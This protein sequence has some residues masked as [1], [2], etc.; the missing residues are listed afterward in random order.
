MNKLQINSKIIWTKESLHKKHI[1]DSIYIKF[2]LILG[3]RI[4][5]SGYLQRWVVIDCEGIEEIFWSCENI[6]CLDQAILK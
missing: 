6:L 1:Y 3:D 4:Q 2:K 5:N